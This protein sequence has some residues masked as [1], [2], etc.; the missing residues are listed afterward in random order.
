MSRMRHLV[1]FARDPARQAREKGFAAPEAASL[2]AR[3]AGGWLE[4]AQRTGARL[5]VSTPAEDE[6]AWR[7]ALTLRGGDPLWLPQSGGSFGERLENAAR[8]AS[9]LG[10]RAVIVGGDVPPSAEELAAAFEALEDGADGAVAPAEDGGVSL[11]ALPARDLDLLRDIGRRRRDVFARLSRALERRGR[12]VAILGRVPDVDGRRDLE[13]ILRS[14]R[15][16]EDLAR[17]AAAA[18]A[19]RPAVPLPRRVFRRR[20][21]FLPPPD[22]RGPP[23]AA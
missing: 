1:L 8:A 4:A 6:P 18:L 23:L 17:L 21:T 20:P 7:R 19:P 5:V 15:L 13:A 11:V 9:D 12:R 14:A 16:S 22:L 10:G 2:F 3:F